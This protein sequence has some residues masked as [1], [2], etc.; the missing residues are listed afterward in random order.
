MFLNQL[1]L[2]LQSNFD[3]QFSHI[4]PGQKQFLQLNGV[5]YF[6]R[7]RGKFYLEKLK[8]N[9]RPIGNLLRLTIKLRNVINW[10]FHSYLK[11]N[12]RDFHRNGRDKIRKKTVYFPKPI[13]FLCAHPTKMD[14]KHVES[15]F[16]WLCTINLDGKKKYKKYIYAGKEKAL[17][18]S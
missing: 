9:Y 11:G 7:Q 1:I 8:S 14:Y 18:F 17:I 6:C 16:F 12:A 15:H 10:R 2:N 3:D 4:L 13:N 5:E